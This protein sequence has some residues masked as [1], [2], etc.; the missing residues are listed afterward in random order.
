MA[1]NNTVFNKEFIENKLK[2]ELEKNFLNDALKQKQCNNVFS[3]GKNSIY[4]I[5]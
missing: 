1:G 2:N 4:R 3:Y 5:L